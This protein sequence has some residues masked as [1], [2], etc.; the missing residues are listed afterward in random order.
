MLSGVDQCLI[1]DAPLHHARRFYYGEQLGM[2]VP[3]RRRFYIY[4][5][6]GDAAMGAHNPW[7][8]F[9]SNRDTLL[10]TASATAAAAT[11]V[12]AGRKRAMRAEGAA[13]RVDDTPEEVWDMGA[14]W[15]YSALVKCCKPP[16]LFL[17]GLSFQRSILSPLR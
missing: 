1:Y 6:S 12:A 15:N 11:V 8:E 7:P 17:L 16:R 5:T 3:D 9:V 4:G 10:G 13:A 2:T 14:A